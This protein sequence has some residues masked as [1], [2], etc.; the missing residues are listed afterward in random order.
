MNSKTYEVDGMKLRAELKR[1]FPNNTEADIAR[2]IGFEPGYFHNVV[3]RN[4]I[5]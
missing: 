3:K 1:V 2:M 4:R 5:G